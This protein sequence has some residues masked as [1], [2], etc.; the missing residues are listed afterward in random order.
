MSADAGNADSL[1]SGSPSA[2]SANIRCTVSKCSAPGQAAASGVARFHAP[3]AQQ[4][5]QKR[6][7]SLAIAP[8]SP[9]ADVSSWVQNTDS[10]RRY[11]GNSYRIV[12]ATC[13]PSIPRNENVSGFTYFS[14]TFTESQKGL[15]QFTLDHRDY[16]LSFGFGKMETGIFPVYDLAY[17]A[18]GAWLDTQTLY[19][20]FHI[21]DRYVGS[22]HMQ[23]YFGENDITIFMKKVEES[24]FTE[25]NGH[26]YGIKNFRTGGIYL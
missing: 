9:Y 14:F 23:F 19:V 25:F 26:L 22:V 2:A 18:S 15:I 10:L 8:L 13:N 11:D 1:C 3:A 6:L 5:L 16:T 24:C 7:A 17:A 21:I 12:D 4:A 20:R